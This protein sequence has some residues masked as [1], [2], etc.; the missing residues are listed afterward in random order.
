MN[1]PRLYAHA[2]VDLK[3]TFTIKS[4]TEER[5]DVMMII[6]IVSPSTHIV[7]IKNLVPYYN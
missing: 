2:L 1:S 6:E 3:C 7:L 4:L 5:A